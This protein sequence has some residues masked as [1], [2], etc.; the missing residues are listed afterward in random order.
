MASNLHKCLRSRSIDRGSIPF[1]VNWYPGIRNEELEG[2][3][4]K[5]NRLA[6]CSTI[7]ASGDISFYQKTGVPWPVLVRSPRGSS[8]SAV[9]AAGGA[10]DCRLP[11]IRW[12][13]CEEPTMNF[14]ELIE[15][16]LTYARNRRTL[17][18]STTSSR[19]RITMPMEKDAD[20]QER[21]S[22]SAA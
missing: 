15:Y 21:L 17:V 11:S 14:L 16:R 20:Q 22:P 10:H 9:E 4:K 2:R 18:S 1:G 3:K 12:L 19:W 13:A 6:S 8:F 5:K 7:L